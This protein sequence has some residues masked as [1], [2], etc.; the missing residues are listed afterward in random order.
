MN[1]QPFIGVPAVTE[2]ARKLAET[3]PLEALNWLGSLDA[4][5]GAPSLAKEAGKI[6]A[7]WAQ[8]DSYT[9]GTWLAQNANHPTY[10]R[11]AEAYFRTIINTAPD[12][13]AAWARNPCRSSPP[14]ATTR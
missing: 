7:G 11:M 10:D 9:A 2:T 1:G 8:Q 6:F 3:S 14:P 12:T 4:S 13:A 5:V